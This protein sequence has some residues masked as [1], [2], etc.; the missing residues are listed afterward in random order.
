MNL[1][2]DKASS[3]QRQHQLG[4]APGG[5]GGGGSS[6][7]PPVKEGCLECLE[8]MGDTHFFARA[9]EP[10]LPQQVAVAAGRWLGVEIPGLFD[11]MATNLPVIAR[12]HWQIRSSDHDCVGATVVAVAG[13]SDE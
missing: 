12:Q 11:V 7:G 2:E 1:C 13:S 4:A 10:K 9:Y 5:G 3:Q 6:S 8:R